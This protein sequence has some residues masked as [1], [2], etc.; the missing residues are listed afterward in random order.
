MLRWCHGGAQ[1][2]R[3][4]AGFFGEKVFEG[5]TQATGEGLASAW[6]EFMSVEN[7]T[8]MPCC[9]AKRS[10]AVVCR[11]DICHIFTAV[12][13]DVSEEFAK[14]QLCGKLTGRRSTSSLTSGVREVP[15]ANS[16]ES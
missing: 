7:T 10:T 15:K 11:V 3:E 8:A 6:Q 13:A 12:R 14:S 1:D 16:V 2:D 9:E 4:S 5:E